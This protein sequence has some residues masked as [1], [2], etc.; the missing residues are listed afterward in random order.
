MAGVAALAT[1]ERKHK[2]NDQK[3]TELEYPCCDVVGGGKEASDAFCQLASK[4]ATSSC[5]SKSVVLSELFGRLN[6]TLVH[7][8][9]YCY[10]YVITIFFF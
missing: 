3:C 7:V 2:A 4:L 9:V 10:I 8:V 6:L 1:E 5:R